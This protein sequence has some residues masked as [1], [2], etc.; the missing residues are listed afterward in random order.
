MEILDRVLVA[1]YTRLNEGCS[2]SIEELLYNADRSQIIGFKSSLPFPVSE[3]M[4]ATIR[5]VDISG[6]GFNVNTYELVP[7]TATVSKILFKTPIDTNT[8]NLRGHGFYDVDGA[9]IYYTGDLFMAGVTEILSMVIS[10]IE[11]VQGEDFTSKI[12]CRLY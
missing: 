2:G 4:T 10:N 9:E 5:S 1:D 3:G 8:S 6:E 7:N 12:T 11:E